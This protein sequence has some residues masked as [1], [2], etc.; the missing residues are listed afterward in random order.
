M[1]RTIVLTDESFLHHE[2]R[3]GHPE[4]PERLE[5]IYA[6]L[7][8]DEVKKLVA[9]AKPRKATKEEIALN[10]DPGYIGRIE[11]TANRG[12]TSLDPDT[13]TSDGSWE[14]ATHAAG[15]VLT[16]IDM[17]EDGKADNAFAL[18]RPPGHH[19]EYARA[20]GFCLFNNIA[21][22]ARYLSKRFGLGRVLIVDW[23]IHHGNGTQNAFYDSAEIL[24]FST[25][26]YPYY[27]GSG[28]F[29]ETGEKTGRGFTVNVP[30]SG[31]Q[32]ESDYLKIF[33]DI[34]G[35]VAAAYRP[36]FILVSAGYDIYHFDPLGTMDVTPRGFYV[37]T[38]FLKQLAE[39]LCGGK[40]LFALEGGYNVKGIAESVKQTLFALAGADVSDGQNR[41]S[42]DEKRG[43]SAKTEDII[44][45]VKNVQ[46]V[47]W[48]CLK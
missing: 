18:V 22:G 39:S 34:L 28:G 30:L 1:S 31:G 25:H 43:C 5:S 4:C 6:M 37:M 2:T 21:I 17:I 44:R 24:Y 47:F 11:K 16:G 48:P 7:A 8:T 3:P 41:A 13:N 35:P 20:M 33:Q 9:G 14:A 42:S 32:G 12:F 27:P 38:L 46:S 40:L 26:Q 23:D 45:K 10:H 29:D 36:E 19:A 15:A